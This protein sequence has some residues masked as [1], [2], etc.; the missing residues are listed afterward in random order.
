[1]V[2]VFACWIL[3]T[4]YRRYTTIRD[5]IYNQDSH[6]AQVVFIVLSSHVISIAFIHDVQLRVE[7]MAWASIAVVVQYAKLYHTKRNTTLLMKHTSKWMR[8]RKLPIHHF[9]LVLACSVDNL[10]EKREKKKKRLKKGERQAARSNIRRRSLHLFM[11]SQQRRNWKVSLSVG[12]DPSVC[13]TVV[14]WCKAMVLLSR[15]DER[16]QERE[17]QRE[18]KKDI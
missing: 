14:P 10:V 15:N 9:R 1:M 16:L 13:L 7:H 5:K 2:E 11:Y 4:K 3:Q 8:R 6:E 12:L 17:R 18:G